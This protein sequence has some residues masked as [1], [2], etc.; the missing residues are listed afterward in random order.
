MD[1]LPQA[2]HPPIPFKPLFFIFIYLSCP[3]AD[4]W[5]PFPY[6]FT[7]LVGLDHSWVSEASH[8]LKFRSASTSQTDENGSSEDDYAWLWCW[9]CA[10]WV[11]SGFAK[12]STFFPPSSSLS[13]SQSYGLLFSPPT[14]VL[15]SLGDLWERTKKRDKK[16]ERVSERLPIRM[17]PY[18][19]DWEVTVQSVCCCLWVTLKIYM[20][21]EPPSQY[22]HTQTQH[23]T[24]YYTLITVLSVSNVPRDVSTGSLS[25]RC[26]QTVMMFEAKDST[27]QPSWSCQGFIC[28]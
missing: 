21:T 20:K 10:T 24:L 17:F 26:L 8:W 13:L 6:C 1:P 23:F 2:P 15:L 4:D 19:Y 7:S 3:P 16:Q 12:V 11:S 18:N 25:W 5:L 14:P 9:R 28:P 22:I 27:A